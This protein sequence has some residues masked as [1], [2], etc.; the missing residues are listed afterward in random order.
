LPDVNCFINPIAVLKVRYFTGLLLLTA[1]SGCSVY[2]PQLNDIP[3]ISEKNELRFDGGLAWINMFYGSLSYGLTKNIAL[4]TFINKNS[5]A[6]YYFQ[7][8]AGYYRNLGGG[9]VTEIWGGYGFGS[10]DIGNHDR[11]TSLKGRYNLSFAQINVGRKD[12]GKAHADYGLGI[13]GGWFH[14]DLMD[15]NYFLTYPIRYTGP[16][17]PL[18]IN[19]FILEPNIFLRLGGEHLKFSLK[20]GVCKSFQHE[21]IEKLLPVEPLNFGLGLNY[22]F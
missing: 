19:S 8:A 21:N 18:T 14:S 16:S 6:N 3:L 22:K 17:E 1:I 20:L 13:K 5:G 4:Q 10:T 2:S 7:N 9:V 11:F 12:V 15:G